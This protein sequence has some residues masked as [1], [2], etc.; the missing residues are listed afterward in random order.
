MVR[1]YVITG[2]VQGV[3]YRWFVRERARALDLSG[4]VGNASDGSVVIDVAGMAAQITALEDALTVGPRG[5]VV[6]GVSV[7]LDGR[8]AEAQL[9]ALPYPFAIDH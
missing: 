6:D 5:A 1:R 8:D 2:H 4:I 9:T 3:G 7:V